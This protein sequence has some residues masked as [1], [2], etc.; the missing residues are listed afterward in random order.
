VSLLAIGALGYG[1][2]ITLWVTGAQELGAARGQLMF[3]IALFVGAAWAWIVLGEPVT[4][5]RRA[6]HGSTFGAS[7]TPPALGSRLGRHP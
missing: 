3:A 7:T 5:G 1:L 6:A 4:A 2:S